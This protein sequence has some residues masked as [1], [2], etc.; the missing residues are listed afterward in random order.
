MSRPLGW[1]ALRLRGRLAS[2]R[3]EPGTIRSFLAQ[4]TERG[5]A[6]RILL[7][8]LIPYAGLVIW[9]WSRSDVLS[10]AE[11][12]T[13]F[14]R[15]T[16]ADGHLAAFALDGMR[17]EELGS[18]SGSSCAHGLFTPGR[19]TRVGYGRIGKGPVEITILPPDQESGR[20]PHGGAVGLLEPTDGGPIRYDHAVA[21][22]QDEACERE[23]GASEPD[24]WQP[25][26]LPIWG[27]AEIGRDFQPASGVDGI[28]PSILVCLPQ[29]CDFIR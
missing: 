3:D 1:L 6:R 18:E 29:C 13:E 25:A 16:V 20:V 15:F 17:V 14:V 10:T 28:A 19:D 7:W 11:L 8:L 23:I 9:I 26:R 24:H 4:P 22:Q 27:D 2:L 5:T 21:I 12:H